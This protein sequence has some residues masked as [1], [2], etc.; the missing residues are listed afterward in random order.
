[1][2]HSLLQRGIDPYA[3]ADVTDA[4][5]GW[6]K[7]TAALDVGAG[8]TEVLTNLFKGRVREFIVRVTTVIVGTATVTIQANGATIATL[9]L[10]ANAADDSVHFGFVIDDSPAVDDNKVDQLTNDLD[11][12][13]DSA[14]TSGAVVVDVRVS[15]DT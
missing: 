8:A 14:A 1:M 15:A 7:Q 11:V 5:T 3:D 12:T 9:V 10:P 4:R 6:L 13:V 2:G